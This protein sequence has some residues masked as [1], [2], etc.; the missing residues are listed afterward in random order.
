[1][2]ITN[3]ILIDKFCKKHA[4]AKE[5]IERWVEFV[6]YANWKNHSE[7]KNDYLSADFV[8][9]NRYV[10]NIKGNHYRMVV[11]VVFFAGR[12][13]IRFVGTHSEYD[14]IKDIKTI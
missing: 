11:M 3:T 7:L 2:I 13:D 12:A 8:G 5:A 14:R 1:M 9:N 4:D 6:Q 10:F